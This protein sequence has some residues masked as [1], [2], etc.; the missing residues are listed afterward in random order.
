ML[1]YVTVKPE[2]YKMSFCR[3]P[4]IRCVLAQVANLIIRS[5]QMLSCSLSRCG[6]L[7]AER[8]GNSF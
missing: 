8:D 1:I 6:E 7:I 4:I 3:R 5:L 2:T